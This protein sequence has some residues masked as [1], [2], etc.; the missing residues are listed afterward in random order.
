MNV[1]SCE[2]F[3]HRVPDLAGGRLDAASA[4]RVGAHAAAC[5]ACAAELELARLLF[6]ARAEP[7]AGLADRIV[8]AVRTDRATGTAWGEAGP[9]AVAAA[10]A[11]VVEG[12]GDGARVPV[13][14]R[15]RRGPRPAAYGY[16]PWWGVAAAGLAALAV[17]IGVQTGTGPDVL[18]DVPVYAREIEESGPWISDDGLLAGAPA[19]D[20]LSEEALRR[21]LEELSTENGGAV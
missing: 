15:S 1:V 17:G 12:P 10:R 16:R 7:P 20:G 18:A 2:D 8:T 3:R 11:A 13:A 21:L 19:L 4:G 6:A 14:L 5:A 9:R